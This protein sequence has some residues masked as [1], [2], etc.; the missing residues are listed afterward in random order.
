MRKGMAVRLTQTEVLK[1]STFRDLLGVLRMD[2]AIVT[3][4]CRKLVVV[5]D[6][7]AAVFCLLHG[8]KI[9]ALQRL[10]RK[11]CKR[12]LKH[13]RMLWPVWLRRTEDIIKQCDRRS[14]FVDR[15]A[16]TTE[17]A[18]FWRSNNIARSLWGRGFQMDVCAA[19]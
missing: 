8:N 12:Q 17:P 4:N 16:F 2:L 9:K 6:S 1:S 11:V 19:I 18:I 15:H 10:V 5:L 13:N 7:L 3:K 14:R